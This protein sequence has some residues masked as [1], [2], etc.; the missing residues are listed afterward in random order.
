M[1]QRD[2]CIGMGELAELFRSLE[3]LEVDG[4]RY[5]LVY[6]EPGRVRVYRHGKSYLVF[7]LD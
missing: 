3:R 7:R 5:D 6:H 4:V 1:S 2:E